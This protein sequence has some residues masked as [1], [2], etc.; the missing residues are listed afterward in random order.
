MKIRRIRS[1][2]ILRY[3]GKYSGLN[4]VQPK[5]CSQSSL[6]Y[7][8]WPCICFKHFIKAKN[9]LFKDRDEWFLFSE[10][11]T[12]IS[13]KIS[14]SSQ[15]TKVKLTCCI[16]AKLQQNIF[17]WTWEKIV[18]LLCLICVLCSEK[19]YEHAVNHAS[20]QCILP[21]ERNTSGLVLKISSL[22]IALNGYW[23][24]ASTIL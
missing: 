16:C 24:F 5:T 8:H 22:N 11:N 23:L 18:F 13:L 9:V 14:C 21:W 4:L 10:T 2:H 7:A 15:T 19:V 12:S 1:F 17:L 3:M 6:A 20:L